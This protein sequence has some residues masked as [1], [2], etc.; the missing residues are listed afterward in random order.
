[1]EFTP[2]QLQQLR[3]LIEEVMREESNTLFAKDK[4]IFRKNLK[5]EDAISLQFGT[6]IGTKICSA[7]DQ[8]LS[9]YGV[10]PVDQP[11]T[12]SDPSGAG[13]AGVDAPARTAINS[14][15]DRLQELGL[16]A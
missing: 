9:F 1:M 7:T 6:K 4:F 2:E 13:A 16:I 3:R 12:I 10:T 5:F 14:I 11:S 15:I 8:K